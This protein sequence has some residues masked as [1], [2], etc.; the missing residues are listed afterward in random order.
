MPLASTIRQ[1][2]RSGT[3]IDLSTVSHVFDLDLR[4]QLFLANKEKVAR[5]KIYENLVNDLSRL[6]NPNIILNTTNLNTFYNSS[7][8]PKKSLVAFLIL[9][10][11]ISIIH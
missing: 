2:T 6:I 9:P 11:A 5:Q 1:Q 7:K 10:S 4:P 3:R 8:T